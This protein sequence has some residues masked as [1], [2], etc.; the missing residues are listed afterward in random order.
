VPDEAQ[1][2]PGDVLAGQYVV[3]RVLG[4]GGMGVVVEARAPA[5]GQRAAIKILHRRYI[6]NPEALARFH[7]EAR[8]AVQI[9]GEHSV[10]VLQVGTTDAGEPFLVMELLE[11]CD[12]QQLLRRGALKVNDAVLYLLQACEGMAEVHSEGIVH[13]DLKP[14]NLFLT[15]AP[16]GSPLVKVL[17]FGI[18]KTALPSDD[19]EQALTMTL[20]AL[21]TPLYMAPEQVR[22]SKDVDRR[23]DIWS[24]G[25]ILYELLAGRP[26]FGGNSVA[27]ITAQ[28]LELDPVPLS[29]LRADVSV[30]LDKVIL[31]ALCKKPG[32]RFQDMGAFA[33]AL[34]PFAGAEGLLHA[35]RA[36]R[37]LVASDRASTPFTAEAPL[38]ETLDTASI[39]SARRLGLARKRNRLYGLL[40]ALTVAVL[41]VFYALITTVRETGAAAVPTAQRGLRV[42]ISERVMN[43]ISS[44]KIEEARLAAAASAA[45]AAPV[46]VVSPPTPS[47]AQTGGR[48]V[49]PANPSGKGAP[50][51]PK[52]TP[53]VALEPDSDPLSNRK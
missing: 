19:S 53:T 49:G 30:E 41:V 46:I 45:S 25:A 11:G 32:N 2:S 22:S 34:A 36:T 17:D 12:F 29:T 47:A 24:L 13:R 18:A 44:F 50:V 9:R 4:R 37:I 20:V 43:D 14:G 21:G 27:H 1:V 35:E 52:A 28:V 40:G 39:T 38:A 16:D 26:A 48:P 8:A 33:R 6:D 5:T 51:R 3:T 23:A 15:R 31:K 7:L 42:A 10:R